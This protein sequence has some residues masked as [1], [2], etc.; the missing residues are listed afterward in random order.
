MG[1]V[2]A[3]VAVVDQLAGLLHVV[4]QDLA[5]GGLEQV[6]GG[7][8]AHDGPAALAVHLGGDLVPQVQGAAFHH[9][10]V[11][12]DPLVLGGVDHVH[13]DAF[14]LQRAV[15]S[16]LAAAFPVEGGGVQHHRDFRALSGALHPLAVLDDG[17]HFG[18]SLQLAVAGEDGLRQARGGGALALPGVGAGVL[19]GAAGPLPLLLHQLAE[20]LLVHGHPPLGENLL[21]QVQG[22][23]VGVV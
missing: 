13:R 3:H 10:P 17:H 20:A 22:E 1:E 2:E 4:P 21:G 18:L 15:V 11:Q 7:V 8:V 5:Q 12:V 23:A 14:R 6:G 19:P 9:S 16:H